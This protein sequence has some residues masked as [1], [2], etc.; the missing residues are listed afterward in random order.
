MI[1]ALLDTDTAVEL[2][3]G[4]ASIRRRARSSPPKTLGI[5][6]VTLYELRVGVEKSRD[7]AN[8]RKLLADALAPFEVLPFDDAASQEGAKVRA[9]LEKKG[10]GIGPY[11]T[12][13]AGHALALG[14]VLV[15][16]N[17]REFSR[18]RGLKSENWKSK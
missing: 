17:T 13:I 1:T 5:S 9:E 16:S 2:L 10:K 8:N 7:A 6:A 18:V 12:L 4:D 11:D 15:T 3:R 14:V